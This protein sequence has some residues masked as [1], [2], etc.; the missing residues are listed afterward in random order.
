M[1]FWRR[2]TKAIGSGLVITPD[3]LP[4]AA[5]A[6]PATD[7]VLATFP[8]LAE[9]W[10]FDGRVIVPDPGI[11]LGAYADSG[12]WDL[13]AT[14]PSVRKVTGF[15]ARNI[16]GI[17]WKVYRRVS[18]TDRQ[19]VTDHP[20]AQVL[21]APSETTTA[22]RLWNS[23]IMDLLLDDRWCARVLPSADTAS[24]WEIRRI[25]AARMRLVSDGWDGVEKIVIQGMDGTRTEAAPR[26]YLFDHG[27]SPAGQANGVSPMVTLRNILAES[28]EAVEYRRQVWRNGARVPAVIERPADA[29][30]W[31]AT[32]KDRFTES[33]ARFIGRS[34]GAGGTPILEDG[35]KLVT[36]NAFTP[37]DTAD[38]EGRQLTDAEVAS[39]YYVAPELVGAREGTYSNVDAFRQMLYGTTL[40]PIVTS[41]EQ[42]LNLLLLPIV[43]PGESDLYIEADV[44]SKLRGSFMEQ[45]SVLQSAV[46]APYMLRSEARAVQNLPY[47]E[48]TDELVTPL[49][50]TIGGLASP[51]DTAPKGRPPGP[52]AP[53][54]DG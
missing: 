37:R 1:A 50:V 43:A 23:L 32:A 19:R 17:P 35:M 34:G 49:N 16:A 27:Y 51:R 7:G 25:P 2:R 31:S 36:V 21:A 33:F 13:Y 39:A 42:A 8:S 40:G 29:P 41:F 10:V 38:I 6:S 22:Y 53:G 14:Q 18:D 20:L 24:G 30:G 46:G 54:R 52:K 47:V 12:G 48:G 44:A 45:A 11:P 15:I 9:P 26:G 5:K 3:G 4:V 28:A